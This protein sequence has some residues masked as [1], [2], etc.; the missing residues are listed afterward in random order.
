M[1]GIGSLNPRAS[2]ETGPKGSGAG[3]HTPQREAAPPQARIPA[4]EAVLTVIE[5]A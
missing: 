2:R 3:E 4:R 1:T 5:Q